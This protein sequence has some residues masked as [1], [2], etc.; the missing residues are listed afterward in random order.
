MRPK[1]L[2]QLSPRRRSQFVARVPETH[3]C[4]LVVCMM[5]ETASC[6]LV[7]LGAARALPPLSSQTIRRRARLPPR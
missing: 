4:G 1:T 2:T 7:S 3:I 5:A 6:R